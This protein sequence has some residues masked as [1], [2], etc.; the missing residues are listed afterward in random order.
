[1]NNW[2]NR[3]AALLTLRRLRAHAII[4]AL[5]LWCVCAVDFARPGPFDLWG[6]IKFQD[7]LSFYI[8]GKFIAQGRTSSL[9]DESVRHSEMMK[10]AQPV[11]FGRERVFFLTAPDS[12]RIPNLYGP[13]V[14]LLFVPFARIPFP[15]AA[16]VWVVLNSLIYFVCIDLF[17]RRCPILQLNRGIVALCALAYPPL[18]HVFVRG[19]LSALILLCFTAAFLALRA[20]RRFLPGIALGCLVLKPQFLV[21]IPLILLLARAWTMLAGLLAS[22]AAQL[23]VARFYFGPAVMHDYFNMLRHASDWMSTAELSLAPIQMHSLRSFWMLLL[24]WPSAA[25]VFYLLSSVAV[26]VLA[27]AI[28]KS[29]YTLTFRFSALL[30]ASV[31]VNPH[32]F[33]YDLLVMAP[34]FLLLADWSIRNV[35]HPSVPALRVLLYLAFLLP[36]FGSVARWT[37]LQLSVIIFVALIWTLYRI[38]TQSSAAPVSALAIPE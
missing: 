22:S 7:F 12:I 31:L 1:M 8:S 11:G 15:A 30:L 3:I 29:S 23:A 34:V 36:L 21:A 10:I 4:L 20:D 33:I 2:L 32:L 17:L 28:W 13:Q 37:H 25:T 5:C 24:P 35:Q 16:A 19:Q 27:T 38:A 18:F 14:C 9:Y 6:N 26:I